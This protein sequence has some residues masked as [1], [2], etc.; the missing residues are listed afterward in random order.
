LD[1][2]DFGIAQYVD[3]RGDLDPAALEQASIDAADES[4]WLR[5]CR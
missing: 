5:A 4:G 1:R 3:L 2:L